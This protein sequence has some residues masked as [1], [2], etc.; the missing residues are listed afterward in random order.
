MEQKNHLVLFG[1]IC[2]E[3]GSGAMSGTAMGFNFFKN[4]HLRSR[5]LHN[6]YICKIADQEQGFLGILTDLFSNLDR[7]N[8]TQ[9][10][11]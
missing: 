1:C 4:V 2:V 7:F 9:P 11:S 6:D 5:V 3:G 10:R 8:E